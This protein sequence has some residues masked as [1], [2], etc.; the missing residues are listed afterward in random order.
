M[1]GMMGDYLANKL[2][3]HVTGVAAYTA[4]TQ[5]NIDLYT[6]RGTIAQSCAGTNFTLVTGGSYAAVD[7]GVGGTN[8]NTSAA[9]LVDNKLVVTFPTAT[10]SWGTVTGYRATDQTGNVLWWG[11]LTASKLVPDGATASFAAGDL[12]VSLPQGT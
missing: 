3:D 9:R 12:D 5:I 4:P 7:A 6:A 1:S 11:D 10:A 8:W 2:N